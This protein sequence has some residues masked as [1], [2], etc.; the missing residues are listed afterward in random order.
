MYKNISTAIIIGAT[1][2]IGRA[3]V[4]FLDANGVKLLL[5]GRNPDDLHDV[6]L[7]LNK[8]HH[9]SCIDITDQK[10]LEGAI[11]NFFSAEGRID[12]LF[13]S[14]GY[15]KRGTSAIQFD[16]MKKMMDV[17]FF[18]VFSTIKLVT[19]I[20]KQQENGK[21]VTVSSYSGKIAR[22]PLG[23]YAASKFA[24]M[25]LHESLYKELAAYGIGVTTIC[26]NLVDTKM[27]SDVNI[28]RKKM[29][30]PNDI[31]EALDFILKLSPNAVVKEIVIQCRQKVIENEAK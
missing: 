31:V 9:Y 18:S 21:I 6:S 28:D 17:N 1:G 19:P 14:A 20:M 30:S 2:G 23:G 10:S 29:L 5:I 27:T 3:V 15:V 12:L 26:P 13:N 7:T 4:K 25:G 11:N 8:W 24:L 16:E 22:A